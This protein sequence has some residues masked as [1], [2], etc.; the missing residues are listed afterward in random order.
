MRQHAIY[1]FLAFWHET[2]KAFQQHE[3]HGG[4]SSSMAKQAGRE[5]TWLN[6]KQNRLAGSG[7]NMQA[8]T[9]DAA[10]AEHCGCSFYLLF[11][12]L[13]HASMPASLRLTFGALGDCQDRRRQAGR[14]ALARRQHM[15]FLLPWLA[16]QTT[17]PSSCLWRGWR[18]RR[19]PADKEKAWASFALLREELWTLGHL[20][21]WEEAPSSMPYQ[22]DK[23]VVVGGISEGS[24]L[25]FPRHSLLSDLRHFGQEGRWKEEGG[26]PCC[27]QQQGLLDGQGGQ[28]GGQAA[29]CCCRNS[30]SGDSVAALKHCS[31]QPAAAAS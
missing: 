10:A 30:Y 9:P 4:S 18:G 13:H 8:K 31:Q 6:R 3:R 27:L 24:V 19:V 7:G 2:E 20:W 1:L 17:F 26:W 28:E 23:I 12:L 22:R 29:F 25:P 21:L 16:P 11:C 15:A 14:L 5:Q